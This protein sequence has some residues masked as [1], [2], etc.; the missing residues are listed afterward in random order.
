[1]S[2]ALQLISRPAAPPHLGPFVFGASARSHV[3]CVRKLNEDAWLDRSDV[4]LWAVADGMGGHAAG[5]VASREVIRHLAGVSDFSSAFA[6]RRN[7]RNALFAANA[8]LQRVALRDMLDTVGSTA[9]VLMAHG[10]HYACT[11]AGDSRAYLLRAGELTRITTDHSLAQQMISAGAVSETEVRTLP[12]ANVITRAVGARATLE[13][14]GVYG[15]IQAGDRFLLC[16]DGLFNVLMDADL[17]RILQSDCSVSSADQ[18]IAAALA[19]G[20]SDN[21]TCM[22]IDA[23]M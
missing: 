15:R 16:S 6:V 23:Q 10:G 13:L 21:I 1:M 22:V 20:A 3:G 19:G 2:A 8:G 7:V 5:D 17:R 4:G 11:W 18:L 9:V 14:D 12:N